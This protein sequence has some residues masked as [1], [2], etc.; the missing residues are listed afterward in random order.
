MLVKKRR[1][2]SFYDSLYE[3]IPKDHL[4]RRIDGA[5][6]FGFVNGLLEGTYCKNFGRPAKEPEM[7]LKLL[8][9][10]RLYDLSDVRVIEEA[11]LNL[12]WM[13]FLDLNPE[14]PLPDASLLAKF[15]TQRL[16][17]KTLDAMISA[18]VTQCIESGLISA[19]RIGIDATHT[20]ANTTRLTPER[21]MKHLAKKILK[22][23]REDCGCLPEGITDDIPDYTQ[24]QDHTKAKE[25]MCDYLTE[26]QDKAGAHAGSKTSDVLCEVSEVLR[27]EK[28]IVQKG[29]RSLVDKDARV[30]AKS[31]TDRFFGYKSE[32]VMDVDDRIITA[33][34]THS[35]EYSDGKCFEELL[36]NTL[37][38]GA[39]IQEVYADKAYFKKNILDKI[40][41]IEATSFIP[42]SACA[43][44]IDEE[45]FSYNKDSDQWICFMGNDTV[46]KHTGTHKRGE[47]SYEVLTYTFD[48]TL[49]KD[50]QKRKECMGKTKGKARKL[51]VSTSTGRF[52]EE[53]QR[54][55][56]P[57]FLE[58]YQ[59]RASIEW[60]N[61]E[62][63]CHH[64]MARALGYSLKSV[65]VQVG[66]TV[67]AVN[68]KR[69]AALAKDKAKD[70]IKDTLDAAVCVVRDTFLRACGLFRRY[71]SRLSGF[72]Y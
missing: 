36:E 67:L 61:A 12:A 20:H 69:M 22:A 35:G 43:Y 11:S 27:D 19:T 72:A 21:M 45:M 13:W 64:G 28:F 48:T 63:K 60:K 8:L 66:L 7:M 2:P 54:Q 4:L 6:D 14:D 39:D 37:S 18:T 38:A 33:V 25:V 34:S 41:D 58:K 29:Q 23:L 5:V 55:K 16:G 17:K 26:L 46:D 57:E 47:K 52:Y 40:D 32:I 24:I 31:K 56:D 3:K 59:K 44:K 10:Q 68:M 71:L 65:T 62:M 30:G 42:V 70:A 9:L 49:C 15:R 1:Q 51:Q 50:C 53:S